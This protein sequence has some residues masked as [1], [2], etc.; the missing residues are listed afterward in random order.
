MKIPLYLL[1]LLKRFGPLHGYQLKKIVDDNLSDFTQIK[2]P[3]IYYHLEKLGKE[4]FLSAGLEQ[5]DSGT[6]RT[7]YSLTIKGKKKFKDMLNSFLNFDYRASFDSDAAF[8]FSDSLPVELLEKN[9]ETYRD[10]MA[11]ALLILKKHKTESLNS[12]PEKFRVSAS[13]IF[14]HHEKHY[15]AEL[16]WVEESLKIYKK[17][18]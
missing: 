10:K 5:R 11:K 18:I 13:V 16:D 7:V 8:F 9:L 15:K 6:E 2:L 3:N 17:D 14:S 4:G 12:I 1:G